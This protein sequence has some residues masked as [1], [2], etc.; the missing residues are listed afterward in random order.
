[1]E[2]SSREVVMDMS[3]CGIQLAKREEN[4]IQ[5]TKLGSVRSTFRS[6]DQDLLFRLAARM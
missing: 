3:Q 4:N 5:P 1:M 2:H 6:T